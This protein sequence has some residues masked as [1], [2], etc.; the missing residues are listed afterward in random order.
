MCAKFDNN[1]AHA[2]KTKDSIKPFIFKVNI[3]FP[4]I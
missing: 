1:L 2:L 4:F 3:E